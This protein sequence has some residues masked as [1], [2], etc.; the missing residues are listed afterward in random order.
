MPKNRFITMRPNL[1]DNLITG[2]EKET[3]TYCDGLQALQDGL[4]PTTP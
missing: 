3:A 1:P 4:E 2:I